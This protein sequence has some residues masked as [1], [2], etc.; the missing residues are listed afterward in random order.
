MRAELI[1]V[2]FL[3]VLLVMLASCGSRSTAPQVIVTMGLAAV[4]CYLHC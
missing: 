1:A 4:C 2:S 3:C